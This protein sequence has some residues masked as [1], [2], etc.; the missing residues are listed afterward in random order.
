MRAKP[1]AG[2]PA[3]NGACGSGAG[4]RG[5]IRRLRGWSALPAA[6]AALLAAGFACAPEA[7][8]PSEAEGGLVILPADAGA[9]VDPDLPPRPWFHDF[10]SVPDG[11]TVSHVFRLKNLET[12][13]VTIERIA[14]SC[15]C[16]V[17]S[18]SYVDGQGQ[19]VESLSARSGAEQLITIPPG[20]EADLEIRIDTRD[21]RTKNSDKLVLV[22]LT[23]DSADHR[24]FKVEAHIKVESP[25]LL[26]PNGIDLESIP[27]SAGGSGRCEIVQA[28]GYA[29]R[30]EG[31]AKVPEDVEAALTLEERNGRSFWVLQAGLRPPLELGRQTRY[32]EITTVDGEGRPYRPI[33][34]GIT[35]FATEDVLAEPARL[36]AITARD[37]AGPVSVE[38]R[39]FSQL[40]GHRIKLAE[41]R[42]E[43][44][45]T[46]GLALS[47]APEA[48]DSAGRSTAWTVTLT[49]QAPA[50]EDVLQGK[51]VAVLDEPDR[52]AIEIP[53]VVHVR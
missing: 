46:S 51:V 50:G 2:T 21:I 41:A 1:S 22:N 17:P 44:T 23:T 27:R 19:L 10:G 42:L 15:G 48:A 8:P 35:G 6:A 31:L 9:P 29:H 53:F 39:V 7:P 28:P 24:Y 47:F 25:F 32:F 52:P 26:T 12:V 30:V 49:A 14:P 34:I 4:R 37:A 20:F 43:G 5:R 36:V 45:D 33:E 16:T 40:A 13:P 11:E 38:A 3:V 18:V